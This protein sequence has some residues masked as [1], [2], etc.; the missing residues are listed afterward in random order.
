MH[1][2]ISAQ[3]KII[4]QIEKKFYDTVAAPGG[5]QF[6]QDTTFN[7]QEFSMIEATVVSPRP[8]C[9]LNR[10]DYFGFNEFP[11]TGDTVMVRYDMVYAYV[12][13]PDRATAIHKNVIL[14]NDQEYWRADILQVFAVKINKGWRMLNQYVMCD[15]VQQKR[16]IGEVLILP[17]H[18]RTEI[19]RDIMRVRHITHPAITP[20][21][22]IYCA[23]NAA[24]Q[25]KIG[26][27]EFYIIKQS[28]I[29]GVA[30]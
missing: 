28:H 25:Y 14:H 3:N 26:Q 9:V 12:D 11:N 30:V 13:Q 18:L 1:K 6:Y 17:E 15:L 21:S 2:I 20:G 24:Q 16:D 4:V 8:R 10:H 29:Q 19:R 7:P 23:P 22:I 27:D 5:M